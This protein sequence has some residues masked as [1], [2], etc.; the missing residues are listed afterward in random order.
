VL[1]GGA[2]AEHHLERLRCPGHGL[3]RRDRRRRRHPPVESFSAPVPVHRTPD[4]HA[5]LGSSRTSTPRR[6]S[7]ARSSP[8]AATT[9]ARET[10]PRSATHRQL[11]DRQHRRRHLPQG[12]RAGLDGFETSS[13]LPQPQ[14]TRGNNVSRLSPSAVTGPPRRRWNDRRVQRSR[15]HR[16]RRVDRSTR[17]ISWRAAGGEATPTQRALVTGL[18][19]DKFIVVKLPNKVNVSGPSA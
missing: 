12:E 15:L 5:Q 3:V 19:S 2:R 8:S 13:S 7:R 6:E 4:W 17:S 10:T 14:D 1:N 16:V 18:A 9:T 11:L